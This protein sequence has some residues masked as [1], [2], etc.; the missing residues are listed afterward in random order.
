LLAAI[1]PSKSPFCREVAVDAIVLV[2]AIAAAV[3]GIILA[4]R[5]S[6]ILGCV[7]YLILASVAGPYLLNFEIGGITASLDRVYLLGLVGAYG[8]QWRLGRTDPKPLTGADFALLAFLGMLGVSTFT[9]DYHVVGPGSVPIVQHL[10][11]GYLIPLVVYWIARQARF[12]E[13]EFRRLLVALTLFGLYLAV[14][15]ILE[16]L[17]QWS[18]VLPHYISNPRLGLH[19][20]RARGP[21]LHSVSYGLYLATCLVAACLWLFRT[22]HKPGKLAIAALLPI[23]LAG[24]F[25]T[26]TRS[27]WL[28]TATGLLLMFVA[29]LRGRQRAALIGAAVVGALALGLAKDEIAALKRDEPLKYTKQSADMRKVFAYVS[30][31]MFLDR[32]I[33]GVG[34][35]HF[36]SEKLV[37]LT[38]HE[39]QLDLE[40]IR[41]YVHH[42]TFLSILTETGLIGLTMLGVVLAGWWRVAWGLSQTERGPPYARAHGLLTLAVLGIAFW[43]MLG[44]EITFSPLDHSLIY[45]ACGL[46]VSARASLMRR[47]TA[48]PAQQQAISWPQFSRPIR[49]G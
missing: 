17:H 39:G 13:Q 47:E 8:V 41:T 23:F 43:Q 34:F 27:V 24:D 38:D 46:A 49:Q 12:D 45:F 32:P 48:W 1:G 18:L 2:V 22:Q 29:V 33:W 5:G 3:W 31:K 14:T 15:G 4:A 26:E 19:F 40:S 25:F 30:W 28:G 35:G 11:N 44:H 16:S 42:N 10:I 9:H 7:L 6:L 37:Y 36:P 21:M 20:G